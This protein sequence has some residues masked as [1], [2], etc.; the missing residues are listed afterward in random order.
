MRTYYKASHYVIFST[1]LLPRPCYAQIYFSVLY[2]WTPSAYVRL[3]IW[4]SKFHTRTKQHSN[5]YF[6]IFWCLES[7][8][9][10]LYKQDYNVWAIF[11]FVTNFGVTYTNHS[12]IQLCQSAWQNNF[13]T[14]VSSRSASPI[15]SRLLWDLKFR[16][17][18]HKSTPPVLTL[19]HENPVQHISVGWSHLY[20][21]TSRMFPS[22]VSILR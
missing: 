15:I 9:F 22:P 7:S 11:I 18:T 20:Y 8:I 6:C 1:P 12:D 10:N 17:S 2:S 16:H 4:Q 14:L 5:L 3:S 19:G 13:L 21:S